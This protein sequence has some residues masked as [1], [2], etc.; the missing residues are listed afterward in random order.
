MKRSDG[1]TLVELLM[2]LA[3]L[4][5]V[6]TTV[7]PSFSQ[8]LA[9][10]RLRQV[11]NELRL[12]LALARSEAIKRNE[13]VNVLPTATNWSDGWCVEIDAAAGCTQTPLVAYVVPQI[14]RVNGHSEV[15]KVAFNSWGR[16]GNC[17]RFEIETSVADRTCSVC[18]YVET[19]G[20]AI[21]APGVCANQCPGVSSD[22]SWS[23]ACSS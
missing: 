21:A 8:L 14:I 18:L 7:V 16:S 3:I 13:S 10:Q 2:G 11:S 20:R 9:E 23:G 17:P 4:S 1:F 19:D 6:T 22:Y 5:I 15:T 12:S